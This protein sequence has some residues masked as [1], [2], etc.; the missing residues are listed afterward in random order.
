MAAVDTAVTALEGAMA[1]GPKVQVMQRSVDFSVTNL[2][3]GDW[4][5]LFQL[6]AGDVVIGGALEVTTAGTATATV[7]L[8]FGAGATL[9]SAKAA[10]ALALFPTTATIGISASTSVADTIDISCNTAALVLGV[11]RVTIAVLKAGDFA[12]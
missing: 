8:G 7:D 11:V 10:S 5:E 2:A 1:I 12:G 6:E 9:M 3:V 4:F